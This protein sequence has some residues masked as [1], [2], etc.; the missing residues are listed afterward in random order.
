[1]EEQFVE[2]DLKSIT[3]YGDKLKRVAPRRNEAAHG[4]NILSYD[5]VQQDKG[6]VY[7][8]DVEKY[9]GLIIELLSILYK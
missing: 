6:N 5:D 7:S 4:G 3:T 2:I 1:M 8:S 9:R